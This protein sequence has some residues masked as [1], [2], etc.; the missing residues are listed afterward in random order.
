MSI[1]D[2]LLHAS[3]IVKHV[4]KIFAHTPDMFFT[5]RSISFAPKSAPLPS[6]VDMSRFHRS[7]LAALTGSSRRFFI[8]LLLT[9]ALAAPIVAIECFD[10]L[11]LAPKDDST[12][13]ESSVPATDGSPG[14]CGFACVGPSEAARSRSWS[15][16][17][18]I[19]L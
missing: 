3:E 18:A 15:G 2:F 12:S 9:L 17:S 6:I 10:N 11:P 14:P 5:A 1:S 19:L 4:S 16:F 8:Y 13:Q 7:F